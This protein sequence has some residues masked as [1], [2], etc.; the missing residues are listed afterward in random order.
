MALI[1]IFNDYER[2]INK[3]MLWCDGLNFRWIKINDNLKVVGTIKS[4]WSKQNY[5]IVDTIIYIIT[6]N[7]KIFYKYV[8]H[9]KILPIGTQYDS[10]LNVSEMYLQWLHY[11]NKYYSICCIDNKLANYNEIG[12]LGDLICCNYDEQNPQNNIKKYDECNL[13]SVN[14]NKDHSVSSASSV[15]SDSSS[16]S[17]DSSSSSNSSSA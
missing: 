6:N 11:N 15:S 3:E 16:V 10:N 7:N 13:F 2:F 12:S 14:K 1:S 4:S 5:P 8:S 9:R 17:S